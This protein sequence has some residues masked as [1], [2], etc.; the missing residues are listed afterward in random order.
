MKHLDLSAVTNAAQVRL[1]ASSVE[2]LQ[3]AP[4]EA[5]AAAIIREIGYTYSATKV[6]KLYGG[7]TVEGLVYT[8]APSAVF[9]G[10]EVYLID[11]TTLTVASNT[12]PI[13]TVDDNYQTGLDPVQFTDNQNY[14]IHNNKKAF[15]TAGTSGA[16]LADATN[17]FLVDAAIQFIDTTNKLYYFKT[18]E[19]T[20]RIEGNIPFQSNMSGVADFEFVLT[21]LT[22]LFGGSATF[23]GMETR[24][25][26]ASRMWSDSIIKGEVAEAQFFPLVGTNKLRLIVTTAQTD[27][28]WST[29][30]R[31]IIN[32]TFFVS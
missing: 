27:F 18:S 13:I 6:Y 22:I 17:V 19:N 26:S 29:P 32:H 30:G 7:Y 2:F 11:A 12:V 5:I 8:F 15:I 25:T 1:K 24:F 31:V 16:G 9:Y 14:N 21:E 23:Q 4:K 10:G 28:N 20:V 3:T